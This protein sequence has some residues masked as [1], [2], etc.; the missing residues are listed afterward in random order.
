MITSAVQS[1]IYSKLTNDATLMALITDV[2]ADH[3]QPN[4]PED[5]SLFPYITIGQDTTAPWD[6]KTYFGSEAAVQ[7][8]VWSRSNNYIEVKNANERVLELLHHQPLAITG[9]DHTM[10]IH[11][12]SAFSIDADGHTKRALMTFRI[13]ATDS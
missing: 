4:E 10:T 12:G 11:Q 13:Y 6:S 9:A 1:A 3:P 8:D 7:I 5:D 2:Y